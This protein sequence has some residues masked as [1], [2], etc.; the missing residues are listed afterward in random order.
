[1]LFAGL[2]E[3]PV[4][5]RIGLLDDPTNVLASLSSPGSSGSPY[6]CLTV[7]LPHRITASPSHCLT[8]SLITASVL[9]SLGSLP[10]LTPLTASVRFIPV[11][12]DCNSCYNCHMAGMANTAPRPCLFTHSQ[13][14]THIHS[15][16]QRFLVAG[17]RHVAAF[18]APQGIDQTRT[19]LW[20]MRLV[21]SRYSPTSLTLCVA[22]QS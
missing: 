19:R 9:G 1:M 12:V 18:L 21:Q 22:V 11:S 10:R 8:V 6:H 4:A 20:G 3:V 15:L 5:A 2:E 17:G 14:H 7:S 13:S 16:T